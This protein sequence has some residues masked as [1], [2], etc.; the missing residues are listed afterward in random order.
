[1]VETSLF[2]DLFLGGGVMLDPSVYGALA[3]FVNYVVW[4]ALILA[5][6]LI[7]VFVNAVFPR[8]RIEQAFKFYRKWPTVI[9]IIGLIQA[10]FLKG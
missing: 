5:V 8:F 6:W 10:Y 1:M 4:F 9:A 3:Y 7:A 2:V